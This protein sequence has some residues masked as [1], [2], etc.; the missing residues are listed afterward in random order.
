VSPIVVV[1]ASLA[2]LSAVDALRSGG[3]DGDVVVLDAAT[4]LPSDRPPLSKQ[5][6]AGTMEPAAA[7]Q[8]LAGRLDDLGVDLRLGTPVAAFDAGALRLD[9]ADGSSLSASGVV[10]ATGATPRSLP[11]PSLG[12]VHVLRTLDDSLTLR[13]D[14]LAGPDRVAVI[15]AGFI[16]AE[17][18]A[19]CRELGLEVTLIE[20]A[21]APMVRVLPEAVGTFVADLHRVH[22]VDVRLGV[23]VDGLVADGGRVRG[24]SL[25]DGSVVDATVVVI[26]IGV[27]PDVAWLEGSGVPVGNGVTCD[28]TCLAAP[29][30]V[31]AGDV[32][33][34]FNPHFGERMRVEQWEHA[35]EQGA[36]AGRRLLVA[37][38]D[39]APFVSVPWF[40][41][42]QYDRK[43][44]MAG[45]PAAT[46]EVHVL[47]GSFEE[48]RFVVAFRRGDRCTGVL[49]VNR[50]RHVV[51][52][53]M[54]L[55]ES[56]D[57]VPIEEL[58][59]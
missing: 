41:S 51:Q 7:H 18:A 58:L 55:A 19:T 39:P 3:H 31:A 53:R 29:G 38:D 48:Q 8:P 52:A 23:G 26:G 44:Q 9:L 5:V 15:G 11:G 37:D 1:G 24:V 21:P 22:G 42:D 6:L 56:L 57:W 34:W 10:V 28:Q 14:L 40:W 32:A 35:I 4:E 47:D 43:L 36:A 17:V 49:G 30:V 2:G 25:A 45:R 12:G 46:D 50:P 59:S 16:G 20:A 13:A 54:R 27:V 33:E